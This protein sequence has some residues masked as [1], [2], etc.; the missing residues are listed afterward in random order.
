MVEAVARGTPQNQTFTAKTCHTCGKAAF[1]LETE[2]AD[3][4]F[5]E[6]ELIQ[7]ILIG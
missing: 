6:K 2:H 5:K 7:G 4:R 1:V 3:G